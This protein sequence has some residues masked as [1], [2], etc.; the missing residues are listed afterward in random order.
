[1]EIT[2]LPHEFIADGRHE[3]GAGVVHKS[4]PC[5]SNSIFMTLKF[6]LQARGRENSW[7]DRTTSRC[8][9]CLF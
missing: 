5:R 8:H 3:R 2:R 1:M 7:L 9:A 4:T 6:D